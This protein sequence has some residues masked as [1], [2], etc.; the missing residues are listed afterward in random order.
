MKPIMLIGIVLIIL[1]IVV[2]A[3]QGITFTSR[4]KIIDLGPI[5]ATRETRKAIPPVV[6]VMA[7]AGGL[8]LVIMGAKK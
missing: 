7:L 2:L 4:E 3:Q 8:V 6:G 5:H 1:G